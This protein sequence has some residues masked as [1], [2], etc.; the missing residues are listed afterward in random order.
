VLARTPGSRNLRICDVAH[1][2]HIIVES[3]R[4]LGLIVAEPMGAL[5]QPLSLSHVAISPPFRH[6]PDTD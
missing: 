4:E 2:R 5:Q 3:L 1:C 6:L